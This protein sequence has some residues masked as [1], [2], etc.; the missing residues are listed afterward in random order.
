MSGA[1]SVSGTEGLAD[2]EASGEVVGE[3]V[4]LLEG[5]ADGEASGL[6]V[7]EPANVRWMG[8]GLVVA[9]KHSGKNIAFVSVRTEARRLYI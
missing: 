7:G 8:E 4:G 9:K 3:S 2:G 6:A 1:Q 5:L